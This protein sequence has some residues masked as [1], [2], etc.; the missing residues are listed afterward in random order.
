MAISIT[1]LLLNEFSLARRC[2]AD[3]LLDRATLFVDVVG[4]DEFDFFNK[5][6]V[7]I[8]LPHSHDIDAL[9]HCLAKRL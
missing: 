1:K 7:A 4:V 5:H 9:P 3:H 2:T 8:Y 6:A